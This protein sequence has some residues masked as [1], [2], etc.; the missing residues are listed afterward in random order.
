[1]NIAEL[2]TP[3]LL[4]DLELFE[5]NLRYMADYV[6]RA[7][8]KLRPHAKAHKCVQIAKRQIAAGAVGVCVATVNE[9]EL[10]AKA[11][12]P[13]VLLTSPVADRG[14]CTRMAALATIAEDISVAVDHLHQV[15]MYAEAAAQ[16]GVKLNMVVDLD[17][18]DHRTGVAPGVAAFELARAITAS[19]NLL[20][21]GLQA[22]SVRASHMQE[23]EG[24]AEYSSGVLQGALDTLLLLQTHGID[25]PVITCGSSGSYAADAA[26]PYVTELQAGSY[27]LMDV[28]YA[29][30]GG[31]P[32]G[33]ALTVLATVISAN[34]V[35]RVT[36]DAGF[37][38]FATDR[39][40]GPDLLK[41]PGMRYAWAG[42]E[43]GYVFFDDARHR[44]ALGDRLR[45]LPPHCDPTVNLYDRI[46]VCRANLVQ[47]V[48]PVMDR[49]AR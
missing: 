11:G 4:L 49:Y 20:F 8:K 9:A 39:P 38:A 45:F 6:A 42:D 3:A 24:R 17:M 13:G 12:I 43:F 10:M 44:L 19:P 5:A 2:P 15:Q 29:R 28:A 41:L 31:I 27:A 30:I 23:I 21:G 35:D 16:A 1:M 7:G 34:H 47:D 37:K 25:T 46:H 22:Y 33:H 40:F 32:F 36:V 14:K 18:G 48:W 26:L